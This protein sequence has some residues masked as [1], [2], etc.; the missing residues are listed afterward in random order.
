MRVIFGARI[1]IQMTGTQFTFIQPAEAKATLKAEFPAMD[2][3]TDPPKIECEYRHGPM[4]GLENTDGRAFL[5]QADTDNPNIQP[6]GKAAI[7]VYA[8]NNLLYT[9][10]DVAKAQLVGITKVDEYDWTGHPFGS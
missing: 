1:P 10:H 5:L 9:K 7:M 2:F 8:Y 4:L 3:T 6:S